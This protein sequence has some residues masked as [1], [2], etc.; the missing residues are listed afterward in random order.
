MDYNLSM[1]LENG[2]VRLHYEVSGSGTP[3]IMLHG[4][5]EDISI[6]EKALPLLE[7][8]FTVYR[9]D[10]RCH[11]ESGKKVPLHYELIADDVYRFIILLELEKPIVYGFSDG[12]IAALMLAYTHPDSVRAIAAS[13][14]NSNPKALKFLHRLGYMK[15]SVFKYDKKARMIATEPHITKAD[16]ERIKV[17]ALI[18]AGEHDM[19]KEEDTKFIASSIPISRLM[20]LPGESHSSYIDDSDRIAEILIDNFTGENSLI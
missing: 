20:I 1:F 4:S 2:K 8:H 6:F 9:I 3:L 13:G 14:A 17:P 15:L 18:T 11:G 12:G 5:G 19:I 16:L 10:S 7:K